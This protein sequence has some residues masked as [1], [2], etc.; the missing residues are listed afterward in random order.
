MTGAGETTVAGRDGG[1]SDKSRDGNACHIDEATPRG[2]GNG[3][4][5]RPHFLSPTACQA[6][7]VSLGGRHGGV[8]NPPAAHRSAEL[9]R[10]ALGRKK[11][12]LITP[13]HPQPLAFPV[14]S[15]PPPPPPH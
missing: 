3:L 8:H 1:A 2:D 12:V 9:L 15:F 7:G 10:G 5:K 6:G 14:C 4:L 13:P 11:T